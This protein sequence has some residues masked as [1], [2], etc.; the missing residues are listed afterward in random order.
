MRNGAAGYQ[1]RTGRILRYDNRNEI[2]PH[3]LDQSVLRMRYHTDLAL[4]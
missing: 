4:L 3:G 2:N 1:F